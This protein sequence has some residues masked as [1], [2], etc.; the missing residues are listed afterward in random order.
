MLRADK[1]QFKIALKRY[2]LRNT[3][4]SIDEFIEHAR[5]IKIKGE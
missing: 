1:S 5:S 3:F 2:L 4:Y